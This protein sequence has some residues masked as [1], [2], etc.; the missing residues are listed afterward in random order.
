MLCTR[1][2]PDGGSVLPEPTLI[3]PV[4]LSSCSGLES[5]PLPKFHSSGYHSLT[6]CHPRFHSTCDH[7]PK[8]ER[9]V[10]PRV[11]FVKSESCPS[12]CMAGWAL[13]LGAAPVWVRGC[14]VWMPHTKSCPLDWTSFLP[15]QLDRCSRPLPQFPLCLHGG[16]SLKIFPLDTLGEKAS[17]ERYNIPDLHLQ[18]LHLRRTRDHPRV[19]VHKTHL[20]A[21]HGFSY[22]SPAGWRVKSHG[23]FESTTSSASY[24]FLNEAIGVYK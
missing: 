24:K 6:H 1:C 5:S 19:T 21:V 3:T 14:A 4:I 7:L 2:L 18:C 20:Y 12:R 16:V 17:F 23:D 9:L 8:L 11:P 13:V 22:I 15:L 10:A